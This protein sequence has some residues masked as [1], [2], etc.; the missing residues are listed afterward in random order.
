MRKDEWVFIMLVMATVTLLPAFAALRYPV[1]LADLAEHGDHAALIRLERS[2]RSGDAGAQVAL[3]YVLSYGH[4]DSHQYA[5][6]VYW[7]KKAAI[8]GDA[9]AEFDLGLSYSMGQGV[10][11]N[12]AKAVYWWKKSAVQGNT[13]AENFLGFAYATGEGVPRN[14][15]KADYWQKKAAV[16]RRKQAAQATDW[17]V[18]NARTEQCVNAKVFAAKKGF[19]AAASPLGLRNALRGQPDWEG[20]KSYPLNRKLGRMV[21][22]H[23]ST[24]YFY[25]FSSLAG[26]QAVRN[27]NLR[28]GTI[29]DLK[30]LQ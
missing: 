10:A 5:K 19:P 25:Y 14:Y 4:P 26:C 1:R 15:A 11:Q 20:V 30:A 16:H 24:N 17:F 18:F 21:A 28:N 2:A 7:Y 6:A 12:Y 9:T 8:Q 22:L 23:Q 3:G 27:H 13:A 29:P